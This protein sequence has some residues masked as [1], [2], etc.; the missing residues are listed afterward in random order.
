MDLMDP[1]KYP[2]VETSHLVIWPETALSDFFSSRLRM[3]CC[4]CNNGQ[5]KRKTDVSWGGFFYDKDKEAVYNAVMAIG[6]GHDVEK[7]PETK[8]SVY[9]KKH[10][11]PFSEY[12]PL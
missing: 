6:E 9:A 1:D 8:V 11:V 4:P 3:S 2:N 7:S 12:I 5:K 10:L